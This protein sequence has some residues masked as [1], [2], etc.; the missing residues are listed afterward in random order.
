MPRAFQVRLDEVADLALETLKATGLNESEAVRLALQEAGQ[1]RR[2][3]SSLAAGAVV[4]AADPADVAEKQALS[5][6]LD[7][8]APVDVY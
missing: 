4:L 7:D 2:T 1:R 5:E 6:L 8:L 3:R